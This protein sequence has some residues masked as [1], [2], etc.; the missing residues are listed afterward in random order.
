MTGDSDPRFVDSNVLVYAHDMDAG[1]KHEVARALIKDLW[2]SG[3]GGLSIQVLQEF[4]VRVTRRIPNPLDSYEAAEAVEDFAQ[5][6]VHA[7]VPGD[8]LN[9]IA[10][11]RRH[12]ISFWDAMILNS[13]SKLGCQIVYSED[14]N[15]GQQYG[16]VRVVNP[17][18]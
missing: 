9:A 1:D 10:I 14:L 17:F 18:V 3:R 8:V 2:E 6:T 7:P 4:F 5:W 15:V 13:A 16:S 11:H 12:G